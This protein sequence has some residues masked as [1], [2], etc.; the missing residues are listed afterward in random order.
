MDHRLLTTQ[1]VADRLAVDKKTV[2]R[3]LRAGKLSGSRIGR[4]YRIPEGSVIALLQ[5]TNPA[6]PAT[7]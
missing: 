6:T 3:Y 1:D 4:D 2:L 5:R 7:R